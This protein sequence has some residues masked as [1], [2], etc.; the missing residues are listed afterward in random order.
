MQTFRLK[1]LAV[2]G[3]V[4][5]IFV[6]GSSLRAN[7]PEK[8]KQE[9]PQ[10]TTQNWAQISIK[11]NYP[12]KVSAAG[13]FGDIVE[14]LSKAIARIDKA[15]D[16]EEITGVILDIKTPTLGWAKLNE[17]RAAIDRVR[18][19]KKKV[20]AYVDSGL[21]MDYLLAAS[22]DEVIMPE[23]AML[24]LVGLRAEVSFYKNL[25]DWLDVEADML[26]I[27]EYKAAAE[28]FTRTEMSP[29]FRAEM[30]AILDDYYRQMVEIIANQRKLSVEQ[31]KQAIDAGPHSARSAHRLGLIDRVA[32]EDEL[33]ALFKQNDATVEVK[34]TKDYAKKKVDTNFDGFTGMIKLMNLMMGID[35]SARSGYGP[36]IAVIHATGVIMP[37]RSSTDMFGNEVLGAETLIKAVREAE[38]DAKVKA[39]VLRVDSPGGSALASDLMWRSLEQ[40]KKP[41]V[42]SMGN[43]AAS[44][45]YYISMGADRIFAEPGTLTGSIGVV[46]GKL[47]LNG[48]FKKVG[49]TTSVIA[50]G[51]NS[52]VMSPTEKYTPGEREAMMAL[53]HEIYDQFTRKAAQGRNMPVEKLEPL[54][55]GRVYT[56]AMAQKIGLVDELGT[57]E[58]AVAYA[59]QLAKIRDDTEIERLLLPKPLSPF[60][61]LFGPVDATTIAPADRAA[62]R[63]V[64]RLLGSES[65]EQLQ[66]WQLMELLGKEPRLTIVPFLLTVH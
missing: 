24:L 63:Q 53:F 60:E 55:R 49:I 58:D 37:G 19:K 8:K 41:F 3:L 42:V 33:P 12:E 48:L 52:G 15:A 47:A 25:L 32:Y 64:A 22:C 50:R 10:T 20:Y 29:E 18:A 4:V 26:R 51:K 34:I 66:G 27:G 43:V 5:A 16:D 2:V 30:E 1:K 6:S 39:I 35:P 54:A 44:G 9:P 14:T 57:L 31:V 21:A 46:G 59:K 28:P 7:T 36:K 23:S 62:A 38:K 17:F 11:G 56:G 13:L 61:Q 40:V 45:G 65:A